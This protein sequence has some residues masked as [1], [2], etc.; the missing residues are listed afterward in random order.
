V[1]C[2]E[3]VATETVG[4]CI[5]LIFASLQRQFAFVDWR[6]E[7]MVVAKLVVTPECALSVLDKLSGCLTAVGSIN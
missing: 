3:L 2:T 6:Q 7:R 1:F 5:R 4:P